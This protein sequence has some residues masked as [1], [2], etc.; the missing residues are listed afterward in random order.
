[1]L[2]QHRAVGHEAAVALSAYSILSD[3]Y[4][5]LVKHVTH[6]AASARSRDARASTFQ[7]CEASRRNHHRNVI[8]AWAATITL[9][10]R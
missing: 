4:Q 10:F 5:S 7:Q 6:S 1:M 8:F 3:H 2:T 9:E